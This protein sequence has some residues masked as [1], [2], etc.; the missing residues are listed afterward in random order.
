MQHLL[1]I[2]THLACFQRSQNICHEI[3]KTNAS[4]Q[5]TVSKYFSFRGLVDFQGFKVSGVSLLVGTVSKW[6]KVVHDPRGEHLQ[7][8][9]GAAQAAHI[10]HDQEIGHSTPRAQVADIGHERHIA[11]VFMISNACLKASINK[12]RWGYFLKKLWLSIPIHF[13][14]KCFCHWLSFI[15]SSNWGNA[16]QPSLVT[17]GN[18]NR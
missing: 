7:L 12:M 1:E 14:H 13:C 10:G 17:F 8:M 16:D 15:V 3:S 6:S 11:F 9:S 5:G 4:S 18:R 2:F